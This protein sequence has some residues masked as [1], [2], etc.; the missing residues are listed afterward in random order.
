MTC[1]IPALL[2]LALPAVAA[3]QETRDTVS[4]P[5]IVVTATRYP[6]AADSVAATVSVLQGDDLRARGQVDHPPGRIEHGK[7]ERQPLRDLGRGDVHRGDG[8]EDL[9]QHR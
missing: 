7:R 6:V 9:A 3:A 4:L 1:A 8:T 2:L 5:E